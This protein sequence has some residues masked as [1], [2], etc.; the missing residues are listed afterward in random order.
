M[1]HQFKA[2]KAIDPVKAVYIRQV[3]EF[4]LNAE[5]LL[6]LSKNNIITLSEVMETFNDT[7]I[8]EMRLI[9]LKAEAKTLEVAITEGIRLY[10][11]DETGE[12]K[13]ILVM[14]NSLITEKDKF[15]NLINTIVEMSGTR[16]TKMTR[17]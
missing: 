13:H 11:A 7:A 4:M 10:H 12:M 16:D 5:V 3:D 2:A 15:K 14:T 8:R 17:S 1:F 9:Q 6:L